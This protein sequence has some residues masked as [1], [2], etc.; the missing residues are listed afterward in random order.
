MME[1]EKFVC[2]ECKKSDKIE[3][4][5]KDGWRCKRCGIRYVLDENKEITPQ[6]SLRG[7]RG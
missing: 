4:I 5:G 2:T 6:L 7:K 3:E 1:T